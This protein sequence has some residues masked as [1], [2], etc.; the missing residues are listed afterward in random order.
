MRNVSTGEIVR[1]MSDSEEYVLFSVGDSITEGLRT[2]SAEATYT[3][4]LARGLAEQF[5]GRTVLRYDGLR[6]DTSDGELFPV[7]VYDGP[8]CVQEGTDKQITV[9]RSGI[10]GNTVRRLLNRKNDFIGKQIEGRC[11]DLFLIVSGINDAL[12]CDPTKYVTAKQYGLDLCELLDEIQAADPTADV[13][14][15]TP[16]F[17]DY[18]TEAVS[19]LDPYV[20]VMKEVAARRHI[21]VIDLHRLWMEHLVMGAENSGQGDWL[22]SP[23][24]H[25]HP[26]D[27]GHAAIAEFILNELF[28]NKVSY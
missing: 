1:R 25:C 26:S 14:L 16:T 22:I 10:G 20:A 7:R 28:E 9:V 27:K 3:A 17:N 18:G 12:D 15:M 24:D 8:H 5:P 13:I 21:P 11:A 2:S 19:T 23:D 4:R 6:K